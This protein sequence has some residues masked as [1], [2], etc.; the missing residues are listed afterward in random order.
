MEALILNYIGSKLKLFPFIYDT[1]TSVCGA[2]LHDKVFCDMFAGTGNVGVGFKPQVKTVLANDM[3]YYAYV[4][5]RHYIGNNNLEEL[6]GYEDYIK[7]L[8]VIKLSNRGFIYDYYC[9]EGRL[10]FSEENGKKID[11]ARQYIEHLF[12][13]N[14]IDFPMFFL[15][16]A[17]LLESADKVANT[18]STYAAFL[19][20]LKKSAQETMK[21]KVA[22]F[23]CTLNKHK[24][25]CENANRLINGIE[26]DILYLDPPYNKRQ[27]GAYYHVLNTIAQY[28]AFKPRGITGQHSYNRSKWCMPIQVL[29]EFE[30]LIQG[31]KF[32]HIFLSYNNEG[33]MPLEQ[34][35]NV[36]QKYGKY[37]LV[38]KEYP[39]FKQDKNRVK[40]PATVMEY[41]HV[42]EKS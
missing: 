19:K 5:N 23:N 42:L 15:L 7:E 33:L 1:I 31:A 20:Q 30:D 36:M 12:R 32:K 27:Y 4:L 37:D 18:A 41:I 13:E 28:I 16:L 29:S 35:R 17:S 10:F 38:S 9:K 39:R 34:I 11:N 22:P 25:Y 24:V 14:L 26:G 21:I 2:V 6:A 40:R 8:N 3:E